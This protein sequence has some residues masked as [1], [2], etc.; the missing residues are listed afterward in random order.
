MSQLEQ[1]QYTHD[2]YEL[3]QFTALI[4]SGNQLKYLY[5]NIIIINTN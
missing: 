1:A 3:Q 2:A 4:N 5:N